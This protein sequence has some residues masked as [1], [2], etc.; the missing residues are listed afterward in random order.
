MWIVVFAASFIGGAYKIKVFFDLYWQFPVVMSLSVDQKLYLQFP[1]ISVCNLNRKMREDDLRTGE[2][3]RSPLMYSEL[4][5][6]QFCRQDQ[7]GTKIRNKKNDEV[8]EFLMK[9]YEMDKE[10]RF[11]TGIDPAKFIIKCS[12]AGRTCSP[13]QLTYFDSFRYG[14][15]ITFNKKLHGVETLHVMSVG[16]GSGLFMKIGIISSRYLDTTHTRGIKVVIHEPNAIPSPEEEGFILSPGYETL[17]SLKQTVVRRLP[18]PYKDECIDYE[19][20]GK[21]SLK[22]RN[23]CIRS[24]IQKQNFEQCGC[25]DKSLGVMTDLKQCNVTDDT[26]ACCLDRVLDYMSSS[27]PAC[28]CPLS[29]KS[30][31]YNGEISRALIKIQK[32][33][34]FYPKGIIPGAPGISP[35]EVAKLRMPRWEDK[36]FVRREFL[37]LNIFYSSL[38][39]QVYE[40]QPKFEESELFSYMGNE[41]GL[42]LG[43]SLMTFFEVLEKLTSFVKYI[44]FIVPSPR[45]WWH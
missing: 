28:N 43:I 24:C 29:C 35:E 38:E 31:Y 30:V 39:R 2:A 14:N 13:R 1:A 4:T 36:K 19:D 15:C 12:F 17:I 27:G 16:I 25:I 33:K 37:R 20:Q 3:T 6:S 8:L 21:D 26:D 23:N 5:S 42:W 7:N 10:T 22:S 9:Y 45:N 32:Y 18:Y 44:I 34:P 41:F 11:Q 40:Q